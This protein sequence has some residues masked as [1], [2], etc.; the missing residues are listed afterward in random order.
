MNASEGQEHQTGQTRIF[1]ACNLVFRVGLGLV[2]E[3][4]NQLVS[5][6]LCSYT[7]FLDLALRRLAF[8]VWRLAFG[9]WRLALLINQLT[10]AIGAAAAATR[11]AKGLTTLPWYL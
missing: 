1:Q 6:L 8:G 5:E 10:R 4:S 2:T 11:D 7:K 3:F 9:V